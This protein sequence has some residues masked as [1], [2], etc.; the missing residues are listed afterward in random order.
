MND[1]ILAILVKHKL[2]PS[3]ELLA[4]MN[5]VFQAGAASVAPKTPTGADAE[6]DA[7][8]PLTARDIA[9]L[10]ARGIDPSKKLYQRNSVFTIVGFKA[11]RW[12]FPISVVTQNGTRYKM[13]VDQVIRLQK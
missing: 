12:K 5:D 2:T 4:A 9:A 6:D 3:I 13:T 10:K 8:E 11:S 7:D 1:A